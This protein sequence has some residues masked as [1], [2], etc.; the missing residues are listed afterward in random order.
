ME[1][2]YQTCLGAK[3]ST[4]N[5]LRQIPFLGKGASPKK[6]AFPC[7]YPCAPTA[8]AAFQFS[9]WTVL[10]GNYNLMLLFHNLLFFKSNAFFGKETTKKAYKYRRLILTRIVFCCKVQT[11]VCRAKGA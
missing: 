3:C 9:A 8:P 6:R 4:W 5:I 1:N 10:A 11:V 2:W 7:F